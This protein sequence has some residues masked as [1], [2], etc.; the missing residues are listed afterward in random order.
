MSERF[1]R[2]PMF[3]DDSGPPCGECS[4][5]INSGDDDDAIVL[6]HPARATI[7][8]CSW[9]LASRLAGAVCS[10]AGGSAAMA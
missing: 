8:G 10:V 4:P 6:W 3:S 1:L 9:I 7:F 5:S 2:R